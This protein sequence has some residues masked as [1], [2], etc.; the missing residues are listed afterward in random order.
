MSTFYVAP[1]CAIF[2]SPSHQD[3]PLPQ[4]PKCSPLYYLA[5][6]WWIPALSPDY[7]SC[8]NSGLR[9]G[10]RMRSPL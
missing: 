2:S 10:R 6:V 4:Q 1:N 5:S 3:S 7:C 9:N 8:G